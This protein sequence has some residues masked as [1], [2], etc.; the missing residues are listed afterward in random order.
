MAPIADTYR[1]LPI[2]HKTPKNTVYNQSTGVYENLYSV[3]ENTETSA[4]ITRFSSPQNVSHSANSFSPVISHRSNRKVSNRSNRKVVSQK[5]IRNNVSTHKELQDN[6]V[7]TLDNFLQKLSVSHPPSSRGSFLLPGASAYG[8]NQNINQGMAKCA[9]S[10]FQEGDYVSTLIVPG[11]VT[12]RLLG[13]K[14][15]EK[16][17][18]LVKVDE[19]GETLG[20]SF[21]FYPEQF[22]KGTAFSGD[23]Y[24]V[25]PDPLVRKAEEWKAKVIQSSPILIDSSTAAR[26][27]SALSGDI[28]KNLVG[29]KRK[30]IGNLFRF[31]K[32][33]NLF[34]FNCNDFAKE[35]LGDVVDGRIRGAHIT[36]Q[37]KSVLTERQKSKKKANELKKLRYQQMR[38]KSKKNAEEYAKS[39]TWTGMASSAMGSLSDALWKS[40]HNNF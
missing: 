20:C 10:T 40:H 3:P 21:G 14:S 31:T 2:S 23:G 1:Q 29:K 33:Y 11:P 39:K 18:S 24:I 7:N 9:P 32:N 34:T 26:L 35:M 15:I 13:G 8:M 6:D 36:T 27:N 19:L 22:R 5:N 4:N 17:T 38:N 30:H 25:S 16:H 28:S 12:G 37:G